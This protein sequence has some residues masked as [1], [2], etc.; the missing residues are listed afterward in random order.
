MPLTCRYAFRGRIWGRRR[1]LCVRALGAGR[2][3]THGRARTAAS[4]GCAFMP[5]IRAFL[6]FDLRCS[7]CLL[8]VAIF[9]AAGFRLGVPGAEGVGD[10]LVGGIRLPVDAVRVDLEQDR[11]A[12]PGPA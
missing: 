4:G 8:A 12:V 1:P 10:A 5:P 2:E 3:V 9:P 6:P 11:N 7:T